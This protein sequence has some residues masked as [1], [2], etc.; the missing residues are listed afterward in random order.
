MF[1]R[2]KLFFVNNCS[3]I[4]PHS[5]YFE[6]TFQLR[7]QYR[8]TYLN[9]YRP[10][11]KN[12]KTFCFQDLLLILLI[13]YCKYLFV[14]IFLYLLI[15]LM[16]ITYKFNIYFVFLVIFIL[17]VILLIIMYYA[18]TKHCTSPTLSI[19]YLVF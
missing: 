7:L 12:V 16:L 11:M 8:T 5:L 9:I 14:C 3:M 18:L 1:A 19:F 6:F 2:V 13:F 17:Y 10:I 15:I 4:F